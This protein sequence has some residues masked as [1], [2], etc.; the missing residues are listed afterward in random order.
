MTFSV[1]L[2]GAISMALIVVLGIFVFPALLR[3]RGGWFASIGATLALAALFAWFQA[4]AGDHS[5]GALVAAALCGGLPLAV[6]LIVRR[7]QRG[8]I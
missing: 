5:R 3:H 6:G 4:Q 2:A 1:A 8:S 7:L